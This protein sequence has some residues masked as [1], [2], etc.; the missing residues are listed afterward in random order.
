MPMNPAKRRVLRVALLIGSGAMVFQ[1]GLGACVELANFINPCTTVLALCDQ[2]DLDFLTH[3][4]PD[5]EFDPSCTIPG[6]CGDLPF[7]DFSGGLF[8]TG[9]GVRGGDPP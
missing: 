6:Q 8:G 4:I 5:F 3:T 9:P 1:F 7:E 2:Q